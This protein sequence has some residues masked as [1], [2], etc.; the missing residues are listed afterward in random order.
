MMTGGN[1]LKMKR[2]LIMEDKKKKKSD[3]KCVFLLSRWAGVAY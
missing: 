3:R 2:S 1:E